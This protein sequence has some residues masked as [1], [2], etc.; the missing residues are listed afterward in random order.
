VPRFYQYLRKSAAITSNYGQKLDFGT[1]SNPGPPARNPVSSLRPVRLPAFG[2]LEQEF[3]AIAA[4]EYLVRITA[5]VARMQEEDFDFLAVYADREHFANIAFLTGFDPRF[6]E[7][8]L[9]LDRAGDRLLLVGNECMGYLPDP[10]VGCQVERFQ[11]F[12]LPGQPRDN[13]RPLRAILSDFGIGKGMRVGCVG[14]K[15]YGGELVEGGACAI[16]VPAYIVDLLRDLTGDRRRVRNAAGLFIDPADGLR[17]INSAGQIAQMEFAAVHTSQAVLGA[18]GRIRPG[19]RECDLPIQE[20]VSGLPL[21]CHP[22]VSFGEKVRRG[23]SSPSQRKATR[24]DPFAVALGLWGSL[25][26]RAGMVAESEKDLAPSLADFYPRFAENY[27]DVVT[28]WYQQV[29]VGVAAGKVFAAAQAARDPHLMEFAVNPGHLIHLDEWLH[30]PFASDNECR[31]RS[32]M[33]IQM[34]I[35][36]VS[37]GPFCYVNAEDGIALADETLRAEIAVRYPD[38]WRRIVARREFMTGTLGIALDASVLPLGNTPG[39][40]PPYSMNSELSFVK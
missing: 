28:A 19:V 11:S 10:A 15:C 23:L 32:G 9:L 14:W 29:R 25:T 38:C 24:G 31:L 26:C 21:S 36:P 16:D 7:A 40:F 5:A 30:S 18:L 22:M 17:T 2:G 35:I 1:V 8:L 27:F 4:A 33:A 3:P 12:S 13:S 6:E 39:W 34:D 37:Q 20:T